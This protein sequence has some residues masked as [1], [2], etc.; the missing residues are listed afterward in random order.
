MK[1]VGSPI[2]RS[3]ARARRLPAAARASSRVRRTETNANSEPTKN[4]LAPTKKRTATSFATT[5]IRV[6]EPWPGTS[7]ARKATKLL[8]GSSIAGSK[9]REKHHI[10]TYARNNARLW[11]EMMSV[12]CRDDENR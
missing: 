5:I 12:T 7:P 3:A 9:K 8:A 6:V 11:G 2:R 10:T 4:A 1:E